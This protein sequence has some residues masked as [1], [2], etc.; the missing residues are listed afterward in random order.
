MLE[1]IKSW[2]SLASAG[3]IFI[4]VVVLR[5]KNKEL[6]RARVEALKATYDRELDK[7]D[8]HIVDAVDRSE[9][10]REAYEK[11]LR[12]YER[13]HGDSPHQ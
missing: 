9:D 12:D 10:A 3:V 2:V 4:L 13:E 8:A 11:A 6:Q 5:F 7:M 1:R